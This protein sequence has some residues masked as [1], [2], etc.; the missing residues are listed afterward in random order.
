MLFDELMYPSAKE[1]FGKI[2]IDFEKLDSST[3]VE[4]LSEYTRFS[5]SENRIA[6]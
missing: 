5:A 3:G 2:I 4:R 6:E 1:K